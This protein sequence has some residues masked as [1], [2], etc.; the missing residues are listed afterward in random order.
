M[1]SRRSILKYGALAAV[2][3]SAPVLYWGRRTPVEVTV[4]PRNVKRALVAWF[5]QTGN[6]ERIG[7][8]TAEVWKKRGIE[9][10]AAEIRE[11]DPS[12]CEGFDLIAVGAPVNYYDVP[13]LLKEW[14][15][16]VPHLDGTPVAA[17]ITH[18]LPPGN[19][20]NTGCA[21][22]ESLAEKGGAPVGQ[23]GFG[24]PGAYPPSWAFDADNVQKFREYPAE[25]IYEKAREFSSS[26]IDRVTKGESLP[27]A[28]ECTVDDVKKYAMSARISKIFISKHTIEKSLCLN[29]GTCR[30]KC[31]A[32]AIDPEAGRVDTKKCV[33]C[34]GCVN[35]CPAQ[36][37]IM[38]M[39]GKQLT[40]FNKFK[41]SH[42]IETLEPAE[43]SRRSIFGDKTNRS[44]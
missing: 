29:C 16:N 23:E 31:P 14:L 30:Q 8:L 3:A 32:G 24:H 27:V 11:V 22:L 35:N 21:I 1:K 41:E 33:V 13:P 17:F 4:S 38:V 15:A 40:G 20:H 7:R 42:D 34:M 26:L 18:G 6:T 37:V 12:I 5:S 44:V 28:R 10:E 39:W 19:P 43:F 9:V 36:A 25:A 2:A